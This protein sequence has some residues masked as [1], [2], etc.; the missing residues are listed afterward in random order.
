MESPNAVAGN[1]ALF[2]VS[3]KSGQEMDHSLAVG[4]A[5]SV[6]S[7]NKSG[8]KMG[9]ISVV[10]GGSSTQ[11]ANGCDELNPEVNSL[12][13]NKEI[14]PVLVGASRDSPKGVDLDES[15]LEVKSPKPKDGAPLHVLD[16]I[17][18]S[19]K[20]EKLDE[21]NF[22]VNS[23]HTRTGEIPPPLQDPSQDSVKEGNVDK[24]N[25]GVPPV[26]AEASEVANAC[27]DDGEYG[28]K[29]CHRKFTNKQSLGGHQNA[30][31]FERAMEKDAASHEAHKSGAGLFSSSSSY[32]RT[33]SPLSSKPGSLKRSHE[34]MNR[35]LQINRPSQSQ[36]LLQ[37]QDVPR[38][39]HD[40]YRGYQPGW[41]VPAPRI[42]SSV[43]TAPVPRVSQFVTAQPPYLPGVALTLQFQNPGPPSSSSRP[44]SLCL[45]AFP[46][47]RLVPG[48]N[49]GVHNNNQINVPGNEEGDD[50]GLDLSLKL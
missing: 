4:G 42:S 12:N 32:S 19:V 34:Y 43:P 16:S 36:L 27:Q 3:S 20:G 21:S 9:L 5:M 8:N 40:V 45:T 37:P 50:S 18:E 24:S 48:R 2:D 31:K 11:G 26:E 38:N 30:H 7:S 25:V 46:E 6:D 13:S 22:Q 41:T 10:P 14:P 35:P 28:C 39:F 33:T 1:K 23:S 44:V 29:Y 17:D 47:S 15:S 49:A